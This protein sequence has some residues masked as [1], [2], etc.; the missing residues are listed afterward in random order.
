MIRKSFS[1]SS[2]HIVKIKLGFYQLKTLKKKLLTEQPVSRMVTKW[3]RIR[4]TSPNYFLP[5]YM[6][7]FSS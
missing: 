7:A 6:F 2:S 5:F 1:E 4:E 3:S